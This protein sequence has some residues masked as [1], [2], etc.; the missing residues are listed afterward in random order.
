[1][2]T[3]YSFLLFFPLLLFPVC[4]SFIIITLIAEQPISS[5]QWDKYKGEQKHTHT[6]VNLRTFSRDADFLLT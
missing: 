1:M 4:L 6:F 2:P 3:V 5:Q